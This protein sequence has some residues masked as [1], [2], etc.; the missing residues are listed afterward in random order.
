MVVCQ[1]RDSTVPNQVIDLPLDQRHELL[2]KIIAPECNVITVVP[3]KRSTRVQEIFT[4]MEAHVGN[5][6]EGVVIKN[7]AAK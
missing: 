5:K 6:F 7:C 4:A 3:A 2:G 1:K